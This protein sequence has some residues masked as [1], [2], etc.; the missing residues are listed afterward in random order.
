M[1]DLQRKVASTAV[2]PR[3]VGTRPASL[4]QIQSALAPRQLMVSDRQLPDKLIVWVIARDSLQV[5]ALPASADEMRLAVAHFRQQIEAEDM[6]VVVTAKNLYTILIAPLT[7][8]P[9]RDIIFVPYKSLHPL[10][11]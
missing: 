10:P 8:A 11:F 3:D 6:A 7:L 9:Q 4:A 2:N 1:L 5:K